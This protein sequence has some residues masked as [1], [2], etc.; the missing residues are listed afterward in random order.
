[1]YFHTGEANFLEPA[2]PGPMFA[3]LASKPPAETPVVAVT[4]IGWNLEG[5]DMKRVARFGVSSAG[6]RASMTN[7]PGLRAQ[8]SFFV[9]GGLAKDVFT[10]SF[11]R[12]E[13]SLLS[14]AYGPGVHRDQ[15]GVNRELKLSDFTSF[16]RLVV[17]RQRGTWFAP[18]Q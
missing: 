1:P 13:A 7:V 11:W 10:V 17:L 4:S 14:Y 16:T 12:D 8:H 9:E 3:P 6:V 18:P 2:A 15:I 5:L